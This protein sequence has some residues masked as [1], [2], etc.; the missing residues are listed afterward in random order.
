MKPKRAI[1]QTLSTTALAVTQNKLRKTLREANSAFS[2]SPAFWSHFIKHYW[3][4]K[5]LAIKKPF[6]PP[7]TTAEETFEAFKKASEE[8]SANGSY[9]QYRFYKG[10]GSFILEGSNLKRYI[11]NAS[12]ASIA[13]YAERLSGKLCGERFGLILNGFQK[14]D[15]QFYLRTREFLRG[16]TTKLPVRCS[17]KTGVLLGNYKKTPFGIHKDAVTVFL[18]VVEGRKRI[19]LWPEGYFRDWFDERRDLDFELLRKDAISLEGKAGDLL[20]W[21][22][23][24]WH[25]GESI[26][27]LS[28]TIS[29]AL[30]PL[31]LSS[32]IL[33]D[34]NGRVEELLGSSLDDDGDFPRTSGDVRKSAGR[35]S[36]SVRLATNALRRAERDPGFA[37]GLQVSWLNLV[38]SSYNEPVPSPLPFEVMEDDDI[39]RGFPKQPILWIPSTQDHIVC[40]ANGHAFTLPAAP[41]IIELFERLNSGQRLRVAKL[42]DRYTGV[43]RRNGMQFDVSAEGIS[44]LL[45]KLYSLRAITREGR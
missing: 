13:D 7:I 1:D 22:S 28:V 8:F 42:I 17:V 27:G 34:L 38:T 40:S 45:S 15:S 14:Y 36:K 44:T 18:F 3:D 10:D 30:K 24:Y 35:I 25:V 16:L 41:K 4:K 11:P 33:G 5:P 21:P 26:G 31:Q 9:V 43:T 12:D 39:V 29:L 2:L 32:S 19:Y 20:Y 6:T 23:S 37:Q